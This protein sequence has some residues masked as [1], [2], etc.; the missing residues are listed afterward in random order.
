MFLIRRRTCSALA[1]LMLTALAPPGRARNCLAQQWVDARVSGPF[2]CRAEFPLRG[3]EGLLEELA[4]LQDDLV[5]AVGIPPVREPIELYLFRDKQSY[6]R[7][8]KRQLPN[9]PYRRAL[10]VKSL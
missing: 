1:F 7:Y 9:V 8:L 5:L 2:V 3:S 4:Q 10:Y 6:S